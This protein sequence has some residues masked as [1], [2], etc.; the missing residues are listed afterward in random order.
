MRIIRKSKCKSKQAKVQSERWSTKCSGKENGKLCTKAK[1]KERR[2][3]N[4]IF[5]IERKRERRAGSDGGSE[6]MRIVTASQRRISFVGRVVQQRRERTAW[7]VASYYYIQASNQRVEN[8]MGERKND[9]SRLGSTFMR[10]AS[11]VMILPSSGCWS[12]RSTKSII[13]MVLHG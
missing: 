5:S 11:G 13:S 7:R 6:K 10:V 1:A 4:E 8:V 3:G 2:K 12:L 9:I